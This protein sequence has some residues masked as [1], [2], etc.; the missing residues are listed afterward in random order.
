M[1]PAWMLVAAWSGA[2]ATEAPAPEALVLEW[3]APVECP[4]GAKVRDDALEL[5]RGVD[6]ARG[7]EAPTRRVVVA[8]GRVLRRRGG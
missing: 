6:R 4:A 1:L 8:N 2:L 3:S 5:V 7:V